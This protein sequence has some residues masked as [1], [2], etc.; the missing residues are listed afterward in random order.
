MSI[1]KARLVQMLPLVLI[2]S[3]SIANADI[4][5]DLTVH[6]TIGA[7]DYLCC[8]VNVP[9]YGSPAGGTGDFTSIAP[10]TFSFGTDNALSWKFFGPEDLSYSA[11]FGSAYPGS[12]VMTG[13]Y[14]L[15]FS[16]QVTSGYA[17]WF[18]SDSSGIAYATFSGQWSNGIYGYGNADVS[19]SGPVDI[20]ELNVYVLPEPS[21]LMLLASGIL[22]ALGYKRCRQSS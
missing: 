13:P 22:G 14:G 20:A 3:V 11:L 9:P 4:Q 15:T 5:Q 19:Q 16:G 12:F 7:A 17:E 8:N 1:L 10:W 6:L 2:W 18:F 21:S